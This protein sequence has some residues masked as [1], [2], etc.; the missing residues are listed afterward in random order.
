M[1]FKD[2]LPS[3][4]KGVW[5]LKGKGADEKRYKLIGVCNI[6]PERE[7]ILTILNDRYQFITASA[8]DDAVVHRV[9]AEKAI[10]EICIDV[11]ES[12]LRG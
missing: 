5:I 12:L 9:D 11:D 7:I 3:L 2:V 1:V 4:F 8:L 6:T 10:P